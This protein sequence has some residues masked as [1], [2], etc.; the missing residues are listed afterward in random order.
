ML[1]VLYNEIVN[2]IFS[3]KNFIII[4]KNVREVIQSSYITLY[5]RMT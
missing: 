3:F 1:Q 2:H 5:M 4:T